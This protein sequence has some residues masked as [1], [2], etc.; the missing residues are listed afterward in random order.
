MKENAVA[1]GG[2]NMRSQQRV[3]SASAA[4][5][6]TSGK[7]VDAVR[8]AD[9]AWLKAYTAKDLDK[10]VAFCDEQG[11]MLMPNA[12]VATGKDAIAKLIASHFAIHYSKLTWHPNSVGVARSGELGY[13]SGT[14]EL[15]FKEAS[16]K[17][18][19]DKGKY[20]IV[21]KKHPDSTWKVLFDMSNSDLP[22]ASPL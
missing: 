9:A 12:P 11:S 7:A 4:H 10:A 14:Y 8:A 18:I 16:G 2:I 6:R 3:V 5:G 19:A 20:L 22:P 15:S 21:W 17:T 13:T 1:N